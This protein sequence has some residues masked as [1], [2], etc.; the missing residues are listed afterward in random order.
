[1][2]WVELMSPCLAWSLIATWLYKYHL[3]K[4]GCH[5]GK[6][7]LPWLFWNW[8]WAGVVQ[9]CDSSVK[10]GHP[11]QSFNDH[12]PECLFQLFKVCNPCNGQACAV[13]MWMQ[14]LQLENWYTICCAYS[15]I[16]TFTSGPLNEWASCE[17]NLQKTILQTHQEFKR[18]HD[19]QLE[20]QNLTSSTQLKFSANSPQLS[21]LS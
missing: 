10:L 5:V 8:R 4:L 18:H 11:R 15:L 19:C 21:F 9:S 20:K 13:R 6:T 7:H 16:G 2:L 12:L 1:M 3:K 17:A 14:P